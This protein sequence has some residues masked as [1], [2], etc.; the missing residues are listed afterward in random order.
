MATRKLNQ[1][2]FR[3]VVGLVMLTALMILINVWTSTSKHAQNQLNGNLKVAQNVFEQ[4]L[5]NRENVLYNSANVLTA[6]FGFKQAVATRDKATIS[7]VLE[8]HSSRIN[9]SLMIL[10]DLNGSIIS[11]SNR[12]INFDSTVVENLTT[13]QQNLNKTQLILLDGKLLSLIHI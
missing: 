1:S 12:Q 9:A 2:I 4:V 5:E 13:N 3:L 8:N 6:D 11:S 7:S 10:S